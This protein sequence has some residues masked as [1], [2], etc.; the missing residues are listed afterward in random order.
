MSYNLITRDNNR[1]DYSCTQTVVNAY[2]SLDNMIR[3]AV[4]KDAE[5]LCTIYNHFVKNSVVTFEE[6]MVSTRGI[7][8]NP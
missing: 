6:E 4:K 2:K 1:L 3:P 7:S 8:G 5:R